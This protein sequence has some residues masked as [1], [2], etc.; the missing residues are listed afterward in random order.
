MEAV[1]CDPDGGFVLGTLGFLT[2]DAGRGT[3]YGWR[4]TASAGT[5]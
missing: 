1:R 5:S 3:A 4:G 2:D